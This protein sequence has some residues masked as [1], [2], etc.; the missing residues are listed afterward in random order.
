M[1]SAVEVFARVM[2]SVEPIWLN[3][4][5]ALLSPLS[6]SNSIGTARAVAGKSR[7]AAASAPAQ[8]WI[9]VIRVERM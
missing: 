5:D 3:V 1:V 7:R 8:P 2:K 9:R 4:A 6:N